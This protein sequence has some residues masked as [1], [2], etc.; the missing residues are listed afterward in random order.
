M[1]SSSICFYGTCD[2]EMNFLSCYLMKSTSVRI[3]YV[4]RE[5]DRRW[6]A[7]AL[8]VMEDMGV[9]GGDAWAVQYCG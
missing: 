8:W 5:V 9:G 3:Q 4:V 7:G 2:C 1:I 6:V